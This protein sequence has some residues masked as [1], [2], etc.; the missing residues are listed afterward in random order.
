MTHHVRPRPGLAL[1]LAALIGL[2]VL[3]GV[4]T[5]RIGTQATPAPGAASPIAATPVIGA[6][7]TGAAAAAAVD[8]DVLFIGA[9]PDDEAFG[10]STY[11]QWNEE[12][13]IT[14]GVVTATR[15]EGGGNAVGTE[16]GPALGLLR[17]AEEHRAVG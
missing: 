15:G 11:G 7:P 17:E 6:T 14:T 5:G 1:A 2:L 13:G 10:L 3:P 9:H 16:E 4:A 12:A 8:L